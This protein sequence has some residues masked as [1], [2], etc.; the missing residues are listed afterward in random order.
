MLNNIK[1]NAVKY[2]AGAS[3]WLN[4]YSNYIGDFY[5]IAISGKEAKQRLKEINQHYIPN[6]LIVGSTKDSNLTLLQY[7]FSESETTIYVCVDGAC[8]LPV[9]ATN[10]ALEQINIQY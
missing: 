8:Q 5:E 9:N 10:K 1:E 4:L 3:N 6:K 7:K 2:G